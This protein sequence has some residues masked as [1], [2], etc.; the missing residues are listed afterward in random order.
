[1]WGNPRYPGDKLRRRLVT[2]SAV[3]PKS[4][5]ASLHKSPSNTLITLTTWCTSRQIEGMNTDSY[6]SCGYRYP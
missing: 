2:S 5:S 3:E 4:F 1:M 6:S